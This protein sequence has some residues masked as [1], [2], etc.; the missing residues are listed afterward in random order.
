VAGFS[1][2]VDP[3]WLF[4]APDID[5]FNRIK[6]RA[7][8][9][10]AVVKLHRIEAVSPRTVILGNSR[11]EVG[12]DPANPNWP[13][14]WRPV[15]NAGLPGSGIA[16][17]RQFLA[18]AKQAGEP[19]VIVIGLEFLDFLIDERATALPAQASTLKPR[20]A[21]TKFRA[22]R[23]ALFS[24]GA[25]VDS[26]LTWAA[27]RESHPT[28]LTG[29]G[30]NPMLDYSE[31]ATREGY[32]ML[33]DQKDRENA[34]NYLRPGWRIVDSS[35]VTSA[36][37]EELRALL[38]EAVSQNRSVHVVFYPYHAHILELFD[39][40][41]LWPLFEQWKRMS[42]Q[43]VEQARNDF[44][45]RVF[46]WDFATFNDY[47]TEEAPEYRT[48]KREMRWYWEAGHFK[49]E[50]G[51]RMIERLLDS[52]AQASADSANFGV[53]LSNTNIEQ[54]LARV[55]DARSRFRAEQPRVLIRMQEI[56]QREHATRIAH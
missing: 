54:H 28:S 51:D 25:L 38:R 13:E 36:D 11:A 45:G 48:V 18:Q 46:L 37:W 42:V 19:R 24:S 56:V 15:F 4:G 55:R 50:L 47:T 1:A 8:Q 20:A 14:D 31:L 21:A 12:F 53:L 6:S 22:Y 9:R 16:T 30:F 40:A 33:F 17:A 35:S 52:D 29:L 10:G 49:R 44:E 5:G 26:L 27:Q 32:A 2:L 34:R 3:Y 23:D 43:F 7:S 41:G 39:L